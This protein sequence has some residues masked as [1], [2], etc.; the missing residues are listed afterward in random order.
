MGSRSKRSGAAA[1]TERGVVMETQDIVRYVYDHPQ[2][3]QAELAELF[4]VTGR[5][6][7]EHV[8]RANEMLA[9]AAR[10]ELA[11]GCGYSVEVL[12][13]DRFAAFGRRI[14]HDVSAAPST[15]RERIGYL[16]NDLLARN[17]WV[18]L[19]DLS[20]ILYASRS[21]LSG[22]LKEVERKLDEYGLTLEKRSHYGIRVAGSEMA[23]RL[24]LASVI[25]EYGIQ[26]PD[27]VQTVISQPTWAGENAQEL[28]AQISSSVEDASQRF[29]FHINTVAYQNLIVHIAIALLRIKEGCYIP[30]E[31]T[32]LENLRE[33]REYAVAREIA[34]LLDEKLGIALPDE[35]VAYIAIHLAGKQTVYSAADDAEGEGLVI[36]DEVW[37]VVTE[38]LE[39]VWETFKFD[40]RN[41]LELRMNLARHIVP[42]AVRL[43]YHMELKNPLLQDIRSRYLLAWTI[44]VTA[45]EVI[46]EHYGASLSTDEIGY[47]ALAFALALERQKSAPVKKN[48]LVVCASGAGSA[49]LLEYR[50]SREF[51]DYLDQIKTCDAL[52]LG[53]VD[54][55]H[56]DYV[57]TTVPLDRALPVPV[58]EVSSFFDA[59]DVNE[60]KDLFRAGDATGV[61]SSHFDRELFFPHLHVREKDDVLRL[62]CAKAAR[63]LGLDDEGRF[64]ELVFA[65][66]TTT[67]TSFGNNIAMP[68]PLEPVSDETIVTV[69]LLDEPVA[70]DT[71]GT[72]VQAVFLISFA[73]NA[74]GELPEFF[75]TLADFFIDEHAVARLVAEQ[76]W[77]TL[78][79]LLAACELAYGTG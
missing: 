44:A 5:T 17:D 6:I 21:V 73:R 52:H 45:A 75:G 40:F 2:T 64:T 77:E 26:S 4:G 48:V 56:I 27:P 78:M 28:I 47:I 68:H 74:R 11:R 7:R 33:M 70:W 53:N 66:E 12:D 29:E 79:G 67:P 32:H 72:T 49:R 63:R 20:G 31:P 62:L 15:P 61:L 35:E 55:S 22:D 50:V 9:G 41:D 18:T 69:G 59:K 3:T 37:D 23:R 43:R 24:C 30:M 1:R 38:V 71:R 60:V 10:I 25:M 19:K 13:E 51:G 57:F 8:R 65:R 16:L 34:R 54:F 36:S 76:S 42:L 58:R 46:D 39:R 14:A